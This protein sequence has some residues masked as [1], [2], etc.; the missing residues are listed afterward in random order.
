MTGVRADVPALFASFDVFALSSKTEGLPLVIPEAMASVLPIV[1]TS[2]GGIPGIVPR[3]V[4]RL[5]PHGDERAMRE[6]LG[7][8]TGSRE[9]RTAL[10]QAAHAYAHARF[11]LD[12]MTTAY[13]RL[14]TGA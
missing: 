5:V 14:Y 3:S 2:V 12:Q 7:E 9:T 8:L 1:A 13:E 4:G 10:G 6:A 11:S